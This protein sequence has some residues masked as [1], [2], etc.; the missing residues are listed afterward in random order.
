VV[1]PHGPEKIAIISSA[2]QQL[3]P[4]IKFTLEVEANDTLLFLE[5]L[6]M[7]RDLKLAM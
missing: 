5:V 6:L 1:W 2:S 7:K 4:T 3:R